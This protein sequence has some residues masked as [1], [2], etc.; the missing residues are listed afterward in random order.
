MK[1]PRIA[2]AV[3]VENGGSGSRSAA[4][5]ARKVMDYFMQSEAEPGPAGRM[6]MTAAPP[7]PSVTAR[8]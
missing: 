3:L 7:H 1:R 2:L 6:L 5:L 4:P 8:Q